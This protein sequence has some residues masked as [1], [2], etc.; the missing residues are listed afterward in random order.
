MNVTEPEV[1]QVKAFA[2]VEKPVAVAQLT[3]VLL[4]LVLTVAAQASCAIRKS[5]AAAIS[6]LYDIIL[7]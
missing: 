4:L 2:E 1:G 7:P 5:Q 6:V 3:T